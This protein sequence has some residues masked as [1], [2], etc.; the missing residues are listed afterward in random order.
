MGAG[1]AH[2]RPPARIR[3]A[4][5]TASVSGSV[6]RRD[7]AADD[8]HADTPARNLRDLR[9]R[10]EPGLE[11]VF[12]EFGVRRR[13]ARWNEARRGGALAHPRKVDAGAIVDD[14]DDH[15]VAHLP[16]RQRDLAGFGLAGVPANVA[17]LDAVIER[18]AQ[19][20]FERTRQLFQHRAIEL[21]L[22]PMD[23]EVGALVEFLHR[24][25]Q[26]P[27]QA[28]R[29]AAER[30]RP[31]REQSL[32]HLAR[33]PRLREERGIGIVQILEQRLLHRRHVV[34]ALGQ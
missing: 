32:L 6:R 19:Q 20:V 13:R 24:R 33:Q 22:A 16:H 5:A 11:Q 9:G 7:F 8:V 2:S 12:D 26:D 25:P 3:T 4:C 17:R 23:L 1:S 15:F 30:H 31:D 21:D 10:R 18:I 14:L 29:Q 34:D 28:L 27:V